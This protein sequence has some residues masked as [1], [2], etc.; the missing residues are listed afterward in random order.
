M[1][2]ESNLIPSFC[3]VCV[4]MGVTGKILGFGFGFGFGFRCST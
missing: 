3:S 1:M 4:I 2:Q